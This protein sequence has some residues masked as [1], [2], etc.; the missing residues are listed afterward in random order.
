MEITHKPPIG[1][2]SAKERK[3]VE[4]IAGKSDYAAV[5]VLPIRSVKIPRSPSMLS[6]PLS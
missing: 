1:W 5:E 4:R 6:V 2:H 3:A